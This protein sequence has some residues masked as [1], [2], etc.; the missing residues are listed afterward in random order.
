MS[1]L[2]LISGELGYRAVIRRTVEGDAVV[3]LDDRSGNGRLWQLPRSV[4]VEHFILVSDQGLS[5]E[6]LAPGWRLIT[7]EGLVELT[8]RYPLQISWAEG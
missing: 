5:S 7:V 4:G 2:Y 8:E 1:V 6:G 3:I